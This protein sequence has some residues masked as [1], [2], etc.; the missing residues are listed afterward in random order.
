M[1]RF[2]LAAK[3]TL[4]YL[5]INFT[6]RI[7]ACFSVIRNNLVKLTSLALSCTSNNIVVWTDFLGAAESI[8]VSYF[9]VWAEFTATVLGD[10]LSRR[11]L[12]LFTLFLVFRRNHSDLV[13]FVASRTGTFVFNDLFFFTQWLPA[14]D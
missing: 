1:V 7:L 12:E 14:G 10:E 8:G 5:L 11:A 4:H 9:V 13:L 3:P 6:L 2:A